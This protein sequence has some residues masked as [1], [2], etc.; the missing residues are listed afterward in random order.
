MTLA[1]I[2]EPIEVTKFEF[3]F[4]VKG[5]PKAGVRSQVVGGLGT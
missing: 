5:S 2:K 1:E 4:D 3:E